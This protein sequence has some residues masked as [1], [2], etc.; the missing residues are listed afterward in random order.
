MRTK[1]NSTQPLSKKKQLLTNAIK[2]SE[3]GCSIEIQ[4]TSTPNSMIL[5]IQDE[6]VGMS[7]HEVKHAFDRVYR[8]DQARTSS[9]KGSGLG[10]AIVKEIIELHKGTIE[11]TSTPAIGTTVQVKLPLL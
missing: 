7:P 9:L 2:Y 11:I 10:L 8:A 4:M 3:P 5:N 6:G 1:K